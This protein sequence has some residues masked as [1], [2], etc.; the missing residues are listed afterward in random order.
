M[1]ECVHACTGM[2]MCVLL[3]VGVHAYTF[4]VLH[5]ERF[6]CRLCVHA[7]DSPSYT[8]LTQDRVCLELHVLAP[9][10]LRH[11]YTY[12]WVCTYAHTC[13]SKRQI[14]HCCRQGYAETCY[15]CILQYVAS[16]L[17][18]VSLT[19][20]YICIYALHTS[21]YIYTA[22]ESWHMHEAVMAHV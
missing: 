14:L 5:S 8:E 4:G 1:C 7:A 18:T 11:V 19:A 20:V 10:T 12:V 13:A 9:H 16:S 22:H 15:L 21:L 17:N 2:G 3:Y 6:R